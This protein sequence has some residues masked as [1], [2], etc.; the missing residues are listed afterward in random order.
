MLVY[1]NK[2]IK[3]GRKHWVFWLFKT[4]ELYIWKTTNNLKPCYYE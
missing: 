1:E 2:D 3:E 4:S